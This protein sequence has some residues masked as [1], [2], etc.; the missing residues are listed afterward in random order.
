[1][2]R[3]KAKVGKWEEFFWFFT[4]EFWVKTAVDFTAGKS[5]SIVYFKR[6]EKW[7]G[8]GETN[9]ELWIKVDY[10][11]KRDIQSIEQLV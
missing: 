1:M 3:V 10:V 8:H 6:K 4:A 2:W 9:F 7:K 11:V 5:D